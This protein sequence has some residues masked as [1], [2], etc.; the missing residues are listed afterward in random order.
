MSDGLQTHVLY[1]PNL[2]TLLLSYMHYQGHTASFIG[3]N[4]G[5]IQYRKVQN[6]PI[7]ISNGYWAMGL[8]V[9]MLNTRLDLSRLPIR[10]AL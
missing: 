5:H 8:C 6:S 9:N 10:G 1:Q 2:H 7:C 3:T 4:V